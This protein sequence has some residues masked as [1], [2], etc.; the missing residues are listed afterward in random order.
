MRFLAV[1]GL[2]V[3][4]TSMLACEELSKVSFTVDHE[5]EA[6]E[7]D[8][9]AQLAAAVANNLIPGWDMIPE[10]ECIEVDTETLAT[11]FMIPPEDVNLEDSPQGDQVAKYKDRVEAVDIDELTYIVVENS[12]SF[13][14]PKVSLYVG[15]FGSAKEDLAWV[16]DTE[17]V[18]AGET[19]SYSVDVT[20]ELMTE[21]AGRLEVGSTF[22]IGYDL[23]EAEPMTLCKGATLGKV[24]AKAKIQVTILAQAL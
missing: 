15:D 4:F 16:A 20:D 24:K 5:T 8:L 13:D 6:Y 21:L 3:A 14:V 23:L 7:V 10:G 2:F 18:K 9:D 12:L 11:I 19:G 22:A 1:L 17:A